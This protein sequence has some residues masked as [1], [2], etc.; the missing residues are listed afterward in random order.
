MAGRDVMSGTAGLHILALCSCTAPMSL[1]GCGR[2][3]GCCG[4]VSWMGESKF[5]KTLGVEAV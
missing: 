1:A 2:C 5:Q 4:R 3:Q